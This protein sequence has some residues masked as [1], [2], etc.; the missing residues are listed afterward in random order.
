MAD[1]QG[2]LWGAAGLAVGAALGGAAG[3]LILSR[4]LRQTRAQLGA[5]LAEARTDPLTGLAN[6]KA[7][8]E[9]LANQTA[10]TRRYG[11][12]LALVL[13]DL[14]QFK[15][16]ND[17]GGHAEGDAALAAFAQELRH[18]TRAADFVAR[19]GGDEFVIL[20]PSTDAEG[21]AV[22]AERILRRWHAA[23]RQTPAAPIG[24]ADNDGTA[25]AASAAVPQPRR[26]SAGVAELPRDAAPPLLECADRA[27]YEAKRSGG[28]CVRT[29]ADR[30][31]G[32]RE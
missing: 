2:M 17:A 5:A 3:W 22:L 32:T 14:D 8:D 11:G 13:F 18:G 28:G 15:Q 31:L 7:F 9:Y 29:F 1:P 25:E 12:T 23:A 16:I 21:A 27:L 4:P 6:R 30:G 26:V 19:I 20:L 10:I 24:R